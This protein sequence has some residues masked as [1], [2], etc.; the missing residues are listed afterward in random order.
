MIATSIAGFVALV[1]G[2]TYFVLKACG[3]MLSKGLFLP[4]R[5]VERISS[6]LLK[7]FWAAEI[8]LPGIPWRRGGE[9]KAFKLFCAIPYKRSS[10]L[11]AAGERAVCIGYDQLAESGSEDT[12]W[13]IANESRKRQTNRLWFPIASPVMKNMIKATMWEFWSFWMVLAM[14]LLTAI[15]NGFLQPTTQLQPGPDAILR[16]SLI[17]AYAVA[18]SC[19]M[20]GSWWFFSRMLNAVEQQASWATLSNLFLFASSEFDLGFVPLRPRRLRGFRCEIFGP[21]KTLQ[22]WEY[23]EQHDFRE[24]PPGFRGEKTMNVRRQD[25]GLLNFVQCGDDRI[26]RRAEAKLQLLVDAETKALEKAVKLGLD[27]FLVNVAIL[28]CICLSTGLAPWTTAQS[29]DSTATQTGLY[30]IILAMSTG[31]TAL[32]SSLTHF[33]KAAESAEALQ[34]L[35]THMFP[36]TSFAHHGDGLDLKA[37]RKQDIGTFAGTIMWRD[38]VHDMSRWLMPLLLFWGPGLGLVVPDRG[39]RWDAYYHHDV[40]WLRIELADAVCFIWGNSLGHA[41]FTDFLIRRKK[42]DQ[43][44][45]AEDIVGAARA[46]DTST[47]HVSD[48]LLRTIRLADRDIALSFQKAPIFPDAPRDVRSL[49]AQ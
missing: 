40:S 14:V 32:I 46:A 27:R 23:S 6:A 21:T 37:A 24:V 17:V 11:G 48:V 9:G 1:T 44:S 18:N 7:E 35:Q 8:A 25:L 30:A 43:A 2:I 41:C 12:W 15:Y 13:K 22:T 36:L 47:V 29:H 5:S 31:V 39:R 42:V 3:P 26:Q 16:L 45:D 28:L 20:L 10:P 38:L 33:H 49:I 34:R 19:H 4:L